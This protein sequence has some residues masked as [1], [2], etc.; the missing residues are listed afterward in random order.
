MPIG[1]QLIGRP[2]DERRLLAVAAALHRV[3][4]PTGAPQ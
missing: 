1:V 2:G 4:H 3:F